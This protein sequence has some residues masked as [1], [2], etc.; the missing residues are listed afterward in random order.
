M[1]TKLK[2]LENHLNEKRFSYFDSKS[3]YFIFKTFDN[4]YNILLESYKNHQ[5]SNKILKKIDKT[6]LFFLTVFLIGAVYYFYVYVK[7]FNF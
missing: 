5:T 3:N 4:I 2:F 1:S 6:Y 7:Y